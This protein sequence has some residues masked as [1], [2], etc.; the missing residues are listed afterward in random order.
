MTGGAAQLH[1]PAELLAQSAAYLG[2][3]RSG[4]GAYAGSRV[5]F[6]PR[7]A[8]AAETP[9][10]RAPDSLQKGSG[11]PLQLGFP[12]PFRNHARS[13]ARVPPH[14]PQPACS[15]GRVVLGRTNAAQAEGT[16]NRAN[17]APEAVDWMRD[18]ILKSPA[19][20]S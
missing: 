17:G 7:A 8:G 10:L 2:Q 20:P 19:A 9:A 6:S 14:P 12:R 15:P 16:R 18:P 1:D 4:R 5:P 13:P 3:G 11:P